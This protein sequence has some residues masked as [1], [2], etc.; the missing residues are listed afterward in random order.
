MSSPDALPDY[1]L[2]SDV[3]RRLKSALAAQDVEA[4]GELLCTEVARADAVIE[5]DNDDWMKEPWA[6][7]PPGA[8]LGKRMGG[9]TWREVAGS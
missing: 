1:P 6:Q 2:H 7:L 5:L 3:V 9:G 8:L 4:V